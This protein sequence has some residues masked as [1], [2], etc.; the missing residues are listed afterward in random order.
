MNIEQLSSDWDRFGR[1]DPM[2]AVITDWAERDRTWS[3]EE[4]YALGRSDVARI[5]GVIEACGVRL[6]RSDA[7]DFGCGAG[8]LTQGLA[9]H[10]ETV[11]GVDIAP[12][13]LELARHHNNRPERVQ[14]VQNLAADLRI[15]CDS[16]F[17]MVL[18]HIVLQHLEPSLSLSYIREFLRVLRPGGMAVFQ[19][20]TQRVRRRF[21]YFLIRRFPRVV[22]A[23]RRLRRGVAPAM[24]MHVLSHEQ[25]LRAVS[26]SGGGLVFLE[27]DEA[28]GPTFHSSVYYVQKR[29]R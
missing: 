6:N 13:M 28:A 25:I 8:R 12:A 17:D 3:P 4:F 5:L 18:S 24:E 20:P 14:F 1:P 2:R 29:P 7:L 19:T 26:E 9:D 16:S 21:R 27:C 10:F 11:T 23:Y 15:F 22:R